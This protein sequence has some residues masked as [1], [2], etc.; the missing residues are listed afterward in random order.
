MANNINA[1]SRARYAQNR[2]ARRAKANARMKAKVL[3]DPDGENAKQR[4]RA[5]RSY[6]KH[7]ERY[8]VN[9]A[10]QRARMNRLSFSI[11]EADIQI[12]KHCP[13]LGIRLTDVCAARV[14]SDS[15]PSLDRVDSTRGYVPGNIEVISWRANRIKCDATIDELIH[16]GNVAARKKSHGK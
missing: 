11:T 15:S 1:L 14:R 4:T 12:P 8:L 9:N 6:R 5:R 16:I 7:P 13:W 2:P 3:A 10:R